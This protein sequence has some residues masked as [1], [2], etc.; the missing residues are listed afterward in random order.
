M[1]GNSAAL[2]DV[3]KGLD[4][5]RLFITNSGSLPPTMAEKVG[6]IYEDGII[7]FLTKDEIIN[8]A[9]F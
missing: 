5:L 6:L 2:S 1:K 3:N 9:I 4:E 8:G 7:K